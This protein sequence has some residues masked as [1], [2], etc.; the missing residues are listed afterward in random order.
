VRQAGAG[1]LEAFDVVVCR[2][3]GAFGRPVPGGVPRIREPAAS[4]TMPS[5]GA[6]ADGSFS[7]K[8]TYREVILC[9]RQCDEE[10]H[11]WREGPP[12]RLAW[13]RFARLPWPSPSRLIRFK[14][15]NEKR[16]LLHT[17]RRSPLPHH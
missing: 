17:E 3:L 15:S 14:D 7:G 1:G 4:S 6:T 12:L 11:G 9:L 16:I 8:P 10:N 5:P 13:K 2:E